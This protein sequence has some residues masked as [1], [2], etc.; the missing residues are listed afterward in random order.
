[1]IA[2]RLVQSAALWASD[3][4][5]DVATSSGNAATQSGDFPTTPGAYQ[6]TAQGS[7]DAFV[8]KLGPDGKSLAY[9]TYLGGS[10]Y[11]SGHGIA[12][13]STGAVYLTGETGPDFP[14]TPHAAYP[15]PRGGTY[16]AF[17]SKFTNLPS[18]FTVPQLHTRADGTITLSVKV[19]G[20][21]SV[22][23]L[24]TAWNDN[25]ARMALLQ[26]AAGRFVYARWHAAT[27]AAR[28]RPNARGRLLVRRHT[29]RVTLR[30]WVTY[31]RTGRH[32]RSLGLYGLH[33]AERGR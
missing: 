25:V 32:S 15:T 29:Y 20:P 21:G 31:T 26:P 24:V 12:V 13:D 2:E 28:V 17:V 9:S 7:Y 4:V 27:I 30:L 10:G 33:L 11:D 14:T 23:V 6:T 19:P 5:L 3:A 8:T 16:D 1:M 22:D 18:D